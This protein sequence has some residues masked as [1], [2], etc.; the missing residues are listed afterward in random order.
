LYEINHRHVHSLGV[1]EGWSSYDP[2]GRCILK[3]AQAEMVA[4]V[5]FRGKMAERLSPPD[6]TLCDVKLGNGNE[7]AGGNR[8]GASE[9]SGSEQ[10]RGKST[11][12]KGTEGS[13]A[14]LSSQE[15][16]SQRQA[17]EVDRELVQKFV[18]S[19]GDEG[20]CLKILLEDFGGQDNFYEMYSILFSEYAIYVLVFNMKW[21]L[22][23]SADLESGIRYLRYWLHSVSVYCKTTSILLVGTHKDNVPEPRLH[24]HVNN[25]LFERLHDLP[26]WQK[27]LW[28]HDGEI[29]TG[30]APLSFFPVDNKRGSS[31]PI[32]SKLMKNIEGAIK[33]S[34]HLKHKV[35]FAW[36]DLMDR[37]EALKQQHC[38]ILDIDRFKEFCGECGFP[39]SDGYTLNSE[40][41]I[42]LNFLHKLGMVMYHHSVP[43]LVILRPAE[44]LFPYFSKII[45][46]F[47]WHS[48]LI[49]EHQAARK[50][51]PAQFQALASKGILNRG[52]LEQLWAG[53]DYHEEVT[54]LMVSL[55]LM[56]PIL[57]EEHCDGE[58]DFLVPA[59]LPEDKICEP[60]AGAHLVAYILFG[61]S[62]TVAE[63][64]KAG[65]LPYSTIE[66]FGY[67]P[68]GVFSRLLG[69]MASLCQ[70]TEPYPSISEMVIRKN[71]GFFELGTQIKFTLIKRDHL[72]AVHIVQGTGYGMSEILQ[73]HLST[74]VDKFLPGFSFQLAI[75]SYDGG[76]TM[77]SG[78]KGIKS[79]TT[80]NEAMKIN[81]TE[82]LTSS[83][84]CLRFKQWIVPRGMEDWY[85]FF[86]SY[87]WNQFDEELTMSLYMELSLQIAEDNHAPRTFLDKMRLE[88][89]GNFITDFGNSLCKSMIAVVFLSAA[90]LKRMSETQVDL[91]KDVSGSRRLFVS[92]RTPES[93]S[94]IFIIMIGNFLK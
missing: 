35:P 38:L 9:S 37:L 76:C 83:E 68:A 25:M 59:I 64:Q 73:G 34:D 36:M 66:Q 55:G 78:P 14:D 47:K 72:I 44:F 19:R 91:N 56:V 93:Y 29:S 24:E 33:S 79:R 74:I 31:D 75:P 69:A 3:E 81:P 4:E 26:A 43:N 92:P 90:A 77:L 12:G 10:D 80:K 46:D 40:A 52:L 41:E 42:A 61:V 85:H 49:P 17:L 15:H 88:T 57:A 6:D 86:F 70:Q 27:I 87:R 60:P 45:C 67:M 21:L 1:S 5:I 89:G 30:R 28:L 94:L 50:A 18:N 16:K 48:S 53:K 54:Q 8:T 62:S 39:S 82:L 22:P 65:Y 2:G 13:S 32:I 58:P 11:L 84:L 51:L 20:E 71:I 23:G 7:A 63:W